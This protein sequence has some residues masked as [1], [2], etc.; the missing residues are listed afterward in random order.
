[1]RVVPVILAGGI[2]ERF[3]PLSRSTSPKQLLPIVSRRTMLE[4]T[5]SR[6]GGFYRK[7]VRP[8]IVTGRGISGRIRKALA[9]RIA[10]DAIIEPKGRNTA[11]AVAIAA[12]WLR[13]KY[14]E[15]T[16]MVVLSADH[17]IRPKADFIANVRYA[18]S[19]ASSRDALVI[20]GIIPNR[21]AETGYGYIHLGRPVGSE[22]GISSY[23]VADF[24]EK[25]DAAT[26]R[27]FTLSGSY[28]WNSGM[29]VWK[30]SVILDEFRSH[31]PK[32]HR[33]ALA[34]ARQKFSRAAVD[35]YYESCISKA[36]D[37]GIMQETD[38]AIAVR[39]TF[40]WDD[41]GSWESVCRVYPPNSRGTVCTG[42]R[43]Y[44]DSCTNSIVVNHS[45]MAVSAIG[46]EDTVV[47]A[48]DDA[49]LVVARDKLPE[50]KDH[51]RRMKS[52]THFP[53]KLF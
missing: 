27:R 32:L 12:T 39:A 24:R 30:V 49:V 36:V 28:L 37:H 47:V 31:M 45:N 42:K 3:W 10:Y 35:R 53:G 4:E 40:E 14:G 26:A 34:A 50:I 23:Y 46:L 19:L 9:G 13:A 25:P 48:V 22:G 21:P 2:G 43:V 17:A 33:Q 44:E 16:V 52:D 11:P 8:L 41:I 29:F 18:V 6:V 15:D 5:L 51:L 20:F 38:R 7:G 1:M